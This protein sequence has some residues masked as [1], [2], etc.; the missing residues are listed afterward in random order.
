MQRG[1][2][3]IVR[4]PFTDLSGSKRRPAVVLA[5]YSPDVVVAFISSV[6]PTVPEKSDVMLQPTIADF[7]ATGLK[8]P[9]VIRL[10]KLATLEQN[11]ITRRMGRLSSGLL[12]AVDEA[13]LL[14]LDIDANRMVAR[15]YKQLLAILQNQGETA[16]ITYIRSKR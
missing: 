8:V 9:S 4:F 3:V 6:V 14:A 7:A 16:V 5:V 15:E 11:L 12:T 1:D 13:L 2:I 10:R